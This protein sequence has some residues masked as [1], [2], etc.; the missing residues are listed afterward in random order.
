MCV[1]VTTGKSLLSIFLS[2]SIM[3]NVFQ[4]FSFCAMTLLVVLQAG[5]LVA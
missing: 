5:R 3:V 4:T 2:L 1:T